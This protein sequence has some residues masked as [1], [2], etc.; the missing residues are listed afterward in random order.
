MGGLA[1]GFP[2]CGGTR[3]EGLAKLCPD[4]KDP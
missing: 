4:P 3:V 1:E 2:F